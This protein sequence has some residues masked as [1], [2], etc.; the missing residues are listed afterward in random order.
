ME[1]TPFTVINGCFSNF[2]DILWTYWKCAC[3]FLIE[4]ESILTELGFFKLRYFGSF[5]AFSESSF[6]N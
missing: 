1:S 5:F 6:C 4:L 2:A 3:G